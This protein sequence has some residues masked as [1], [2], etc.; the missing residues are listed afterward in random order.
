MKNHT[1]SFISETDIDPAFWLSLF[2]LEIFLKF[3]L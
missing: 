2:Y 3:I 1:N